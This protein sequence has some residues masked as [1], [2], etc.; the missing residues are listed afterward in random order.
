[1]MQ[2]L[3]TDILISATPQ[4]I[5]DVLIIIG[6]SIVGLI[7]ED[8]RDKHILLPYDMLIYKEYWRIITSGFVHGNTTH[9]LLNSMTFF[10]FSFMVEVKIGHLEFAVLYLASLLISN[11]FVVLRYYND[12]GYDGS[13]GA[14]GAI[15]GVVLAAVMLNPHL[16]FGIPIVSD[17]LPFLTLPAY[18]AAGIYILYTTISMF[19]PINHTINHL[20]H[21]TG[22]CAGIA[23]SFL[24]KPGLYDF[25]VESFKYV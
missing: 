20:A 11:A 7:K 12:T 24:L 16:T 6:V 23:L 8:F 9:L 22:A 4:Q 1:M 17:Y 14:S 21:L 15:S 10:F 18:I 25:L 2:H 3:Q 19:L 13:L 5:W